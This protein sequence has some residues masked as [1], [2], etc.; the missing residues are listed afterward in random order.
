MTSVA[1]ASTLE[2]LVQVGPR[3]GL[4]EVTVVSGGRHGIAVFKPAGSDEIYAV[5]NR[6]PHLGFPLHRGSVCDGILTCHWHHARFDLRSGGTFDQFA[7]D[8][9]TYEVI[10]RDDIIYVDPRPRRNDRVEHAQAR[11]RDGLEQS[12]SLVLAKNVLA[13]LE[14]GAPAAGILEIGGR[15]GARYRESGWRSGLTILTAM[16]NVLPSLGPDDRMLALYHGL[17]HVARD[18]AG[19]PPRHPL[20]P[21][22]NAAIPASRLKTWFRQ[23]IEVRDSDGAERVLLTAI[24][25][26][27]SPADLAD[28][29]AS[30]ATDHAFLDGGHTLDFVNKA[31]ELLDLIGCRHAATI[32]PSLTPVIARSTRSEEL[33]SWRRPVDLVALLDPAFNRVDSLFANAG[34]NPDWRAPDE[35]VATLL[36]DDP[37]AIVAALTAAL[38]TGA[39]PVAVSQALVYAAALRVAH[40]HT[41]N[42]FSDWIT[43][44][45][46]FTYLN[47]THQ[48]MR[49][50]PSA[51]LLRGVYHGAMSLYLDRFLN[52]PP[53]RLPEQR[54]AAL[55]ALPAGADDLLAHLDDTLDRE[56]QVELAGQ[57]TWRYLALGHDPNP[58]IAALGHLLLRE[59]GEFHSYQMF[60]AGVAL[61]RE[62]APVAPERAN[63][64]L[65][66]VARY[67]AGHAP[68]SRAMLQTARTARRLARGEDLFDAID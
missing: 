44:L 50:A 38:E 29:L 8:V 59:D 56:Q 10:V 26:G 24:E 6:C 15:F 43:V 31:C 20:D 60:E 68:T 34:G 41:S 65:V 16:G 57:L 39:P 32:L 22:P 45:H 67:L 62:L 12:I 17:V 9:Q 7:D 52:V 64:V 23:F 14:A 49:R 19:Q 47:A 37:T 30:A 5:D 40:F 21:L 2:G 66:A 46:T 61:H 28:L 4:G 3:D 48:L 54:Q 36:G 27:A 33:N 25:Q 13:L 55:D 51:E 53:A 11:L 35:L 18:S 63:R 1:T 58:L 42:E